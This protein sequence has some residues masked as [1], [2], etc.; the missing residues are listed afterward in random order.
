MADLLDRIRICSELHARLEELRPSR[1]HG[2][3]SAHPR[4]WT[5]RSSS[6]ASPQCVEVTLDD[7]VR[8]RKI[9][10]TST[11]RVKQARTARND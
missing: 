9:V 6:S 8:L 2:N 10:L 1:Q 4:T 7:A 5:R 11:D 3:R